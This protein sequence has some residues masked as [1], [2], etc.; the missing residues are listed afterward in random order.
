MTSNHDVYV[1]LDTSNDIEEGCDGKSACIKAKEQIDAVYHAFV[2][3]ES[4]LPDFKVLR[5]F[6]TKQAAD[7]VEAFRGDY[8]GKY[9]IAEEDIFLLPQYQFFEQRLD[10][11][12]FDDLNIETDS[13]K[14]R[15]FAPFIMKA[16]LK[17]GLAFTE[18]LLTVIH[19]L[20]SEFSITAIHVRTDD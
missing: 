5:P 16:E 13:I 15:F 9:H 3:E 8:K 7:I 17:P 10:K 14:F 19:V 12:T 20:T 2:D 4:K 1:P 11:S 18:V 6:S